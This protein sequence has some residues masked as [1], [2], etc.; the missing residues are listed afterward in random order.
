MQK[1]LGSTTGDDPSRLT[2]SDA[3]WVGLGGMGRVWGG[4]WM[5]FELGVAVQLCEALWEISRGHSLCANTVG[6][7]TFPGFYELLV[8]CAKIS[9]RWE[10]YVYTF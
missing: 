5:L 1:G 3:V 4:G 9:S 8:Q 6:F 2:A 7:G 10:G